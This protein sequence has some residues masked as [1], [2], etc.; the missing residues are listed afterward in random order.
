M[1]SGRYFCCP[2]GQCRASRLQRIC[3]TTLL[4]SGVRQLRLVEAIFHR[5][6]S[7]PSSTACL[8]MQCCMQHSTMASLQLGAACSRMEACTA[9]GSRRWGLRARV[10]PRQQLTRQVWL[11]AAEDLTYNTQIQHE[12]YKNGKHPVLGEHLFRWWKPLGVHH[13]GWISTAE[14]AVQLPEW[15]ISFFPS[16]AVCHRW[17]LLAAALHNSGRC[18][19][20]EVLGSP[21]LLPGFAQ[22]KLQGEL[23]LTDKQTLCYALHFWNHHS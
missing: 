4:S 22:H 21:A 17:D 5:L 2:E 23:W 18:G 20:Q 11:Q 12:Q 14:T 7:T 16:L 8:Q 1:Q 19:Y 15:L 3:H 13:S 6:G 10:L 9:D